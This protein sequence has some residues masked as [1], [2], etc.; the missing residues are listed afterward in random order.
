MTILV[1]FYL[2]PFVKMSPHPRD[3]A[4]KMIIFPEAHFYKASPKK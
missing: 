4:P 1:I 2:P 3:G